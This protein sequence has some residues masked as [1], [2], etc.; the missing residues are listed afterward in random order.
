LLVLVSM[1]MVMLRILLFILVN[2]W[3]REKKIYVGTSNVKAIVL[4]NPV[5]VPKPHIHMDIFFVF[6]FFFIVYVVVFFYILFCRS[7]S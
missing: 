5:G 4:V 6:F 2:C 1:T 7:S 3:D